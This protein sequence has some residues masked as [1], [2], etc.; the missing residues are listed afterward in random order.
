[1]AKN[2][3]LENS[4]IYGTLNL[5]RKGINLLLLPILTSYLTT[6]DFGIVAV[7]TSIN[8]FLNVVYLLGLHGSLNR[9]YFEYRSDSSKVQ[10]LFGTSLTVVLIVSGLLTMLLFAFHRILLNP[11]LQEVEF[12]PYM[13][14]GLFSLLLNPVFTVYQTSLQARQKGKVYG[15]NDLLFFITNLVLLL[16]AVIFLRLGAKGVLGSLALT[17][18]F[19]F[20]YTLTRFG[21]EM[22]FGINRKMLRDSL[23]YSIPFVPHSLSAVLSSTVDKIF[24]NSILSTSLAGI[25][26][27][28]DTFGGIVFLIASGINQAFVPWFNEQVKAE[29]LDKVLNPSKVLIILYCLIALGVSLFGKYII[30][31]L[32]PIE[33]HKSWTVI[34][35]ISFSFVFHG[36]YYFYSMPLL[37]DVSGKGSRTL[38]IFTIFS[39]LLNVFL[40]YLL[41]ARFG[42]I[43]A[44]IATLFSKYALVIGLNFAYKKFIDLRYS[45]SFM[46]LAPWPFFAVS[47]ILNFAFNA[48]EMFLMKL[49]AYII[50]LA[51][52]YLI[53]R[54]SISETRKT[55]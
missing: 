9:F 35:F 11:F 46:L 47:I 38:P 55:L 5:F 49:L 8:A 16:I 50:S 12:Y 48:A 44:G 54:K 41:I 15:R 28:G 43:G 20:V 39:A 29:K 10:E 19:F 23:R 51:I 14:I 42:I 33:Y 18:L 52:G 26:K 27:V 30:F 13:A 4:T 2:R 21:K 1:M 17:N 22:N 53:M 25:Y 32:T 36:V 45:D 24:I 37:Y 31:Y 3:L 34:T 6:Y 7:V 40:N